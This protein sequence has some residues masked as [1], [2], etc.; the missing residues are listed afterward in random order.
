MSATIEPEPSAAEREAILEALGASDDAVL[1]E[2]AEA[3]LAEGAEDGEP[4]R[5]LVGAGSESA[6]ADSDR[7]KTPEG[8][9]SRPR[10]VLPPAPLISDA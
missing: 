6:R 8:A 9:A 3:A 10:T 7:A 2:W 1:G 5:C 4:D